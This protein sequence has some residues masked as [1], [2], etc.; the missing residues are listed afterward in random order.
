MLSKL[1]ILLE[2]LYTPTP[3]ASRP[4]SR[5][6]QFTPKTPKTAIQLRRQSTL[7]KKLLRQRSN[8]PPSPSK[9]AIDQIVKSAYLSMHTVAILA[10]ENADLR[11]AN[12]KK[13]QKRTR[14]NRQIA[15]EEGRSIGEG[16]QLAQ[17]PEQPVEDSQVISY[18]AGE[19]ANQADLPRRRA[20]KRC[21]GCGEIDHKI[22]RCNKR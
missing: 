16:L 20:P 6:S 5:S 8:S 14:S 15:L 19:S 12:E 7:V 11:R 13:R 2:S 4:S 1:N 9:S 10:Q 17:Q 21:S 3:L 22:T 18:K